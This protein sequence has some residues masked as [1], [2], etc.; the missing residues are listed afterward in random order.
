MS[1]LREIDA[2]RSKDRRGREDRNRILR[3]KLKKLQEAE[4]AKQQ[5]QRE[6]ESSQSE[7]DT[8]SSDQSEEDTESSDQSE[9]DTEISDQSENIQNKASGEPDQKASAAKNP[10]SP[11]A[12]EFSKEKQSSTEEPESEQ[13]DKKQHLQ[14][15]STGEHIMSNGIVQP[16]KMPNTF[17][18]KPNKLVETINSLMEHFTS[19]SNIPFDLHSYTNKMKVYAPYNLNN[20]LYDN[21]EYLAKVDLC[22]H[23]IYL[24]AEGAHGRLPDFV[25]LL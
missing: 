24:S 3:E 10:E 13:V 23:L 18:E 21:L 15:Q 6:K 17:L 25:L 5:E 8:E 16:E 20:N 22:I 7:E 14:K 11:E 19:P 4:A 9:D 12:P 2:K 1:S